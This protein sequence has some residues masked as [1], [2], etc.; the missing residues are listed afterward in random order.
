[1]RTVRRAC[2]LN[3]LGSMTDRLGIDARD[4]AQD[5]GEQRLGRQLAAHVEHGAIVETV[6]L[7]PRHHDLR[8]KWALE[9]VVRRV[10]H[11]PDDLDVELLARL[12]GHPLA[13]GVCA[14][15]ET[16]HETLVDDRNGWAIE[17]V[18]L[19]EI[20]TCEQGNVQ[21][22]EHRQFNRIRSLSSKAEVS[23][24]M[25][26]SPGTRP[27]RISMELTDVRPIWTGT[28]TA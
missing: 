19:R 15:A 6:R 5:G 25:T 1:M 16:P 23:E 20:A 17:R 10:G 9:G 12:E 24:R 26:S 28:R 7:L 2:E 18:R 14:K 13:D 8:G 22:R 3:V 27:C 21:V 11:E 4:D